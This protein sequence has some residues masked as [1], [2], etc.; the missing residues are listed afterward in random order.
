MQTDRNQLIWQNFILKG[1]V[2]VVQKRVRG[3]TPPWHIFKIILKLNSELS[4]IGKDLGFVQTRDQELFIA[5]LKS[6]KLQLPRKLELMYIFWNQ[7]NVQI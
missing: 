2:L 4:F 1:S 5:L 7:K 6:I 3:G